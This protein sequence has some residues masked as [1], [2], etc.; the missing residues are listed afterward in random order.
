MK[1]FSAPQKAQ[2]MCCEGHNYSEHP[3]GAGAPPRNS[4]PAFSGEDAELHTSNLHMNKGV[5]TKAAGN[6]ASDLVHVVATKCT[7]TRSK[8]CCF[9]RRNG[10]RNRCDPALVPSGGTACA[11]VA[12]PTC[13]AP[14]KTSLNAG[15][16]H[17]YQSNQL[18]LV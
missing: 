14:S 18:K 7:Q 3:G 15:E 12:P 17:C 11:A 6:R 8:K 16:S 13:G 4:H 1:H 5:E 2:E 9:T 10:G